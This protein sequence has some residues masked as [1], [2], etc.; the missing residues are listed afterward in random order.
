[1]K[2]SR[3]LA[4]AGLVLLIGTG[5]LAEETSYIM[6]PEEM[7]T[8][9]QES[10][11]QMNTQFDMDITT[12][13]QISP[14]FRHNSDLIITSLPMEGD[15]P[16]EQALENAKT[17]L[18]DKFDISAEEWEAMGVYPRLQDYVYLDNESEWEFYFTPVRDID[19]TDTHPIPE[20]GEYLAV[21]GAR[22]GETQKAVWYSGGL[23]EPILEEKAWEAALIRSEMS[24]EAF[25]EAFAPAV[26]HHYDRKLGVC[27]AFIYHRTADTPGGD[28]HVYQVLLDY[29]TGDVIEMEYTNG[30]G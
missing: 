3:L 18:T 9:W 26:V 20:G 30:V 15:L 12:L 7:K 13:D 10:C 29:R 5:T 4:I 24:P 27:L 8:V 25:A 1:M 2:R 22:T 28:N 11:A 19:V 16:Y 14:Y 21:I 17:V 23:T 6:T